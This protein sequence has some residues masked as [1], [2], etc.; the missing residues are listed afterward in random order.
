LLNNWGERIKTEF[1][2]FRIIGL[3]SDYA[4]AL[5][6]LDCCAVAKEIAASPSREWLAM[7]FDESTLAEVEYFVNLKKR[8]FYELKLS[9]IGLDVD[10]KRVN[11]C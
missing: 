6:G 11:S 7:S 5:P 3:S 4:K 10:G 9:S 8:R 2:V 1:K